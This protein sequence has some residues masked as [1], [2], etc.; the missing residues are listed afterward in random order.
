MVDTIVA[1][2]RS[3][4]RLGRECELPFLAGSIAFFAFLSVVPTLMLVLVAGSL[5]GGE[6]FAS[7][8][9]DLF[10]T[11]LSAE[12]RTVITEAL[13]DPSGAVGASLVGIGVLLWS[14]LKVFLAIDIAFNRIYG[15][16]RTASLAEKLR[17]G[18]VVIATIGLCLSLLLFAQRI[19][20]QLT[21]GRPL[22]TTLISLAVLLF[23]LVFVL[24]PLYYVMPPVQLSP[25]AVVP[26]AITAVI[27]LIALQQGFH[28]Y[29]S[30]ARQYQTYGFLGAVLLFQL[31]LYFGALILLFGAVVNAT[32][33]RYSELS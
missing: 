32:V 30:I 22:Y 9:V 5:L 26:G 21:P 14:A 31:W 8:A 23:G 27:G 16:E 1:T 10:K 15:V 20:I 13:A 3:V 11:Y 17:N 19:A 25:R 2:V 7:A 4:I 33:R 24:V 12:G 6:A 18:A 29:T 28:I